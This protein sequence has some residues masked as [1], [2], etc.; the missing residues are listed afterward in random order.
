M[1]SRLERERVMTPF[2]TI[3][4]PNHKPIAQQR[5]RLS[6]GHTFNPNHDQKIQYSWIFKQAMIQQHKELTT[7]PLAITM[8]F[9]FKRVKSNKRINMVSR[10]DIDNVIKFYLDAMNDIVFHDDSFIIQLSA[11]KVYADKPSVEITIYELGEG[12]DIFIPKK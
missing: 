11:T 7:E 8:T 2:F 5:P 3:T 10:P 1:N 6:R 4:I 9:A 12:Y